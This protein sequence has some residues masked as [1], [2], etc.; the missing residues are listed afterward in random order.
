MAT[1]EVNSGWLQT[2]ADHNSKIHSLAI[3]LDLIDH[4]RFQK[5]GIGVVRDAAG[6]IHGLT[7]KICEILKEVYF[8]DELAEEIDND[9]DS[10]EDT[11]G[12]KDCASFTGGTH[13]HYYN[14]DPG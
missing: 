3:L 9:N 10:T 8:E 4:N 13:Y 14:Q 12:Q 1:I 6:F 7:H 2:I 11:E 5:E